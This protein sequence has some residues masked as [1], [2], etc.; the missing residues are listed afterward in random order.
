LS[1]IQPAYAD[2]DT[3]R[4]KP[5]HEWRSS[6]FADDILRIGH[7]IPHTV[8]KSGPNSLESQMPALPHAKREKEKLLNRARRIRGLVEAIE[9]ALEDKKSCATVLHLIVG[10]RGAMNSLM[11]EVIEDHIQFHVVDPAT[12][13]KRSRGAEELVETLKAYLK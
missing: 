8:F 6:G 10:A 2:S 4:V 1:P 5:R 12:G 3:T 9:R 13:A 11:T 7:M